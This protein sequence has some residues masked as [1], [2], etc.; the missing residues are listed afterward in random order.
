[1]GWG[2]EGNR[3]L[4]Q[5]T[6]PE[7]AEGEKGRRGGGSMSGVERLPRPQWPSVGRSCL[8]SSLLPH[9]A[10][11]RLHSVGGVTSPGGAPRRAQQ[12]TG[13]LR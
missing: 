10:S 4:A 5:R 12:Q 13:S 8:S 3:Q 7:Q 11:G 1:M 6:G 9:P 2:A